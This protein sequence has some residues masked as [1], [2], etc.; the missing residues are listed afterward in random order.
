MFPASLRFNH[1][2]HLHSCQ[3]LHNRIWSGLDTLLNPVQRVHRGLNVRLVP[4]GSLLG[5]TLGRYPFHHKGRTRSPGA[6]ARQKGGDPQKQAAPDLWCLCPMWPAKVP[7]WGISVGWFPVHLITSPFSGCGPNAAQ[8]DPWCGLTVHEVLLPEP[9][10]LGDPVDSD[11]T[12][13]SDAY[14]KA[15]P[16]EH[17]KE[18]QVTPDTV[19]HHGGTDGLIRA[20]LATLTRTLA[21]SQDT[22]NGSEVEAVVT[23]NRGGLG[24]VTYS[25]PPSPQGGRGTTIERHPLPVNNLP[26]KCTR[27]PLAWTTVEQTAVRTQ[28][29]HTQGLPNLS[30]HPKEL[31]HQIQ[32]PKKRWWDPYSKSPRGGWRCGPSTTQHSLTRPSPQKQHQPAG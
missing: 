30:D 16:W 6:L 1:E 23:S 20:P 24:P 17:R 25:F 32:V 21:V 27:P 26:K 19:T 10:P 5:R 11:P 18:V 2:V 3:L 7:T 28:W 9:R 22:N 29:I 14:P 15:P 31:P 8:L 12:P 13:P 4:L